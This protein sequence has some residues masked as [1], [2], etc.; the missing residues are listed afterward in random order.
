MLYHSFFYWGK[1]PIAE[2]NNRVRPESAAEA[3]DKRYRNVVRILDE[4]VLIFDPN[5]WTTPRGRAP[6]KFGLT[7]RCREQQYHNFFY[8]YHNLNVDCIDMRLIGCLI[9]LPHRKKFMKQPQK[10]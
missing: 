2:S 3:A 6:N 7:V 1:S 8:T 5:N 9:N 4:Q 10:L